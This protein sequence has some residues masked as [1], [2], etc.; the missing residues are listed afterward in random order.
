M[1]DQTILWVMW[2]VFIPYPFVPN[3]HLLPHSL[4]LELKLSLSLSQAWCSQ[5]P[6]SNLCDSLRDLALESVRKLEKILLLRSY[7]LGEALAAWC[8]RYSWSL[9]PRRLAVVR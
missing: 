2:V 8:V 7:A 9:A 1:F 6:C 3:N 5:L 4:R